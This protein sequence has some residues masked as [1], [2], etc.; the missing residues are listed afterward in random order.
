VHWK[1][2]P[3]DHDARWGWSFAG[4]RDCS[5]I[6]DPGAAVNARS[7]E[8]RR[9]EQARTSGLVRRVEC[10]RRHGHWFRGLQHLEVSAELQIFVYALGLTVPLG[11]EVPAR[12]SLHSPVPRESPRSASASGSS[13][14]TLVRTARCLLLRYGA[15]RSAKPWSH[16]VE[17]SG[18]EPPTPA[19]KPESDVC[20][21]P[22]RRV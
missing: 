20:R 15:A 5:C 1:C 6:G 16:W 14:G 8:G 10:L 3:A 19:C 7:L 9:D 4:D 2:L 17:A 11:A 18:L 21:R 13:T 22:A 12:S